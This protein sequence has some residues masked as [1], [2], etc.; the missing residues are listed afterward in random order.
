MFPALVCGNAAVLKAAEDTPLTAWLFAAMAHEA[1]LPAGVLNV[2]Q[3]LGAEAGEPLVAHPDVAV[4][5]FTGSTAVGRRIA[6]AA[7][8]RLARVSLEL[9]GKNPF[10][11]ADDADLDAALKWAM[12]SAFSNAGQRCAAGSRIIVFEAVYERFRDAL[13]ARA[14]ACA[15][16][17]PTTTTTGRSSTSASSTTCSAASTPHAQAGATVLTGGE[18][19]TDPAH[20]D[21]FYLAPTL[22][23]ASADAEISGTEL[24]GP[25]ATLY[26]V[27]DFEA[28]LALANVRRTGSRPASTR[29]ACTA[30]PSSPSG[31]R[32]GWRW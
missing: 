14:K 16:G 22:L 6:Q 15:W 20:R 11:V 9:G 12:L 2:I 26:R 19:L 30:R 24:F 1:G 7:G 29:P 21:G 28:A 31:C 23:E 27:P 5:S 3:G 17:R 32:R 10:V 13:V 18:R 25:V 4:L 8:A